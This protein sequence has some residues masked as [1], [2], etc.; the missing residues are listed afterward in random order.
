MDIAGYVGDEVVFEGKDLDVVAV[1]EERDAGKLI[2]TE[3]DIPEF[4]VVGGVEGLKAVVCEIDTF[5]RW[6]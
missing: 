4:G 6:H 2:V 1:V 3:V 5:D